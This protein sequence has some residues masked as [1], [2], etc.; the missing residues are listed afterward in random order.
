MEFI[1]RVK[2]TTNVYFQGK[3]RK[4]HHLGFRGMSAG[5]LRARWLIVRV[6]PPVVGDSE[7]GA[8]CQGPVG[9]VVFA[10]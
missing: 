9:G 2:G 6:P 8:G 7:S 4:L 1:L 5:A 10:L 3:W